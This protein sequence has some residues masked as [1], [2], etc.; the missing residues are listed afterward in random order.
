VSA[1]ANPWLF[2]MVSDLAGMLCVLFGKRRSFQALPATN[3]RTPWQ[4]EQCKTWVSTWECAA[5]AH[6]EQQKHQAAQ[7]PTANHQPATGNQHGVQH[8]ITQDVQSHMTSSQHP[9]KITNRQ[10]T[11]LRQHTVI[12]QSN[13]DQLRHIQLQCRRWV[14]HNASNDSR[15]MVK[16]DALMTRLPAITCSLH[17]S[18]AANDH[19]CQAIVPLM[20]PDLSAVLCWPGELSFSAGEPAGPVHTSPAKP[21][22]AG[23]STRQHSAAVLPGHSQKPAWS[24][25]WSGTPGPSPCNMIWRQGSCHASFVIQAVAPYAVYDTSTPQAAS[26]SCLCSNEVPSWSC[27]NI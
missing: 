14:Q 9:V 21:C 1:T 5:A 19:S 4:V 3:C 12:I 6:M 7:P 15:T 13:I 25:A 11:N 24:T 27:Y 16:Y 23:T 17:K 20:P 26:I 22:W 18:Q 8:T 2:R 10:S